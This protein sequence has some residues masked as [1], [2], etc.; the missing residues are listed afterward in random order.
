[1]RR[2]S[3][4]DLTPA[5]HQPMSNEDGTVWIVFSGEIYNS[6]ALRDD[7]ERKGYRFRNRTDTEVIVHLY[8][9]RSE[10]CVEALRGMFA[11]AIWDARRQSLLLARDRI[12][13]KPLSYWHR[14]GL[15]LF[16]SETELR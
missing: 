2:L 10:R 12:G 9:E 14:N 3:I 5:S 6:Q 13:K 8:E 15:F 7:L 1:M 11:F 16:T 4:I